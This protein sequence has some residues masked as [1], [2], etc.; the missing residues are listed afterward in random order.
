MYVQDIFFKK[1]GLIFLFTVGWLF[2]ARMKVSR[3]EVGMISV[4][5][6]LGNVLSLNEL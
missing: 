3:G 6:C 2:V 1:M 5:T 4:S